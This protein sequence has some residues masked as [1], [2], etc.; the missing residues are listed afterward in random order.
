[1]LGRERRNLADDS[2]NHGAHDHDFVRRPRCIRTITTAT[3]TAKD[4]TTA[5]NIA[6]DATTI[7]GP[8]TKK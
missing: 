4:T 3:T 2:G 6:T 5:T 8:T 7:A 1:M